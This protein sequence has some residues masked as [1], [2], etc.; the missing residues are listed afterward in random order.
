MKRLITHLGFALLFV[1]G[2]GC[3]NQPSKTN[4]S[5][6]PTPETLLLKD[7][8]PQSIY[9]IPRT[10]VNQARFPVIDIHSHPYAQN[11]AEIERW[12]K[13][14]DTVGIE[15]TIILTCSYGAAFDSIA[16]IYEKYGDRFELWCGF[17]YTGYDQPGWSQRA[18]A[19]LERCVRRG[20]RGV[21]ELVDKG[22]GMY[23]SN[24]FAKRPGTKAKGMHL[25]DPRMAPLL[26]KCAELGIPVNVHVADP[27]W[28]YQPMDSTNDGLMNAYTWRIQRQPGLLLHQQLIDMLENA[29]KNH[30][31]TT[32]IACH[33]ANLSYDL[34]QLGALLDKY[35]NLWADNSARYA[36]TA[37][38]P[39]F[40]HAFY[41]KYQDRLLYGTDNYFTP[42][43]YQ[44]TFRILETA[45]EHF[46]EKNLFNY[47]WA[48]Y[49]FDLPTPVLK[50]LY[51]QNALRLLAQ[52]D[53]K[54]RHFFKS[55]KEK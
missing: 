55:Q 32:F 46:Y 45:D 51:R 35:P 47:H 38:I 3:S 26:E 8:H 34:N 39:R 52:R 4:N 29:V 1:L 53:E 33:F 50:K 48:Y 13:I 19:E 30:P 36:E 18:V 21:G 16:A 20:A 5:Q 22:L 11:P 15:K 14:M 41:Q 2:F 23:Y 27:I 24:L 10:Q 12:I 6:Q 42:H 37:T 54:L 28:M 49:G 40:V 44:V 17:D 25:D 9:R 31:N 7:Y 43:M